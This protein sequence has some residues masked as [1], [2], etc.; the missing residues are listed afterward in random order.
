M[1]HPRP[2]PCPP[3]SARLPLK[4]CTNLRANRRRNSQLPLEINPLLTVAK[5]TQGTGSG[6]AR[7][8][9]NEKIGQPVRPV[10]LAGLVADLIVANFNHGRWQVPLPGMAADRV[11][12]LVG[13]RIRLV[14]AD[15]ERRVGTQPIG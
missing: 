3:G 2:R 1:P 4:L 9:R 5:F 14:D 6:Q 10:S 7:R 8:C 12:D 13:R 11:I 15:G